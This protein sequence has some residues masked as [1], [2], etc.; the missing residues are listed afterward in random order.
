M[1]HQNSPEPAG[2]T[3]AGSG[4]SPITFTGLLDILGHNGFTAVCLKPVDGDFSATVTESADAANLAGVADA[5][6][7]FGVNPVTGPARGGRGSS[8]DV[9]ALSCL[10]VDFDVK[11]GACATLGDALTIVDDLSAILGTRPGVLIW[12]GHGVQ[13]LW[14]IEDDAAT[15]TSPK[16]RT[17]AVVLLKRWRRLVETVAGQRGAGVDAVFDLARILRIPG[18][19]NHKADPV[20]VVAT[21]DRGGPLTLDEIDDVLDEFGVPYPD[22]ESTNAAVD[23]DS[24]AWA[25][26]ACFYARRMIAGWATDSPIARHPWLVGQATRLAAARRHGCLTADE[27]QHGIDTLTTRMRELCTQ[28][29]ARA[30]PANEIRDAIAWGEHRVAQMSDERAAREL[31]GH[32][33]TD[34][35][36]EL[37]VV[38]FSPGGDD[39][40]TQPIAATTAPTLASYL[41]DGGSFIHDE[42]EG[43]TSLW[44][45]GDR[46][47]W[48]DGEALIICGPQGVGKTTLASNVLSALIADHPNDILGV[49]V[50]PVDRTLYLAMDRPRQASRA[51][52]RQLGH[53]SRDHLDKR[54]TF[55]KGPPP[56]DLAKNTRMLTELAEAAEADVVIV[57][58]LKDAAIGL[59]DDEVGAG[60]NRAR[61]ALLASGRNILELHHIKKISGDKKPDIADVYGSTWI[62]S[63]AGSVILLNGNPGDA[64]VRFHHVKQPIEE[65][66]PWMLLHEQQTGT[67]TV[68][69]QVDIVAS[70]A[71]SEGLTVKDAARLVFE[72]DTPDRNQIEKTRRRLNALVRDG[73]LMATEPG[74]PSPT[75]YVA[76]ARQEVA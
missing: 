68:H 14:L 42:P 64:V 1:A 34:N 56:H 24:F 53:Y 31:G 38:D 59:S 16:D 60:W 2:T 63:G 23:P 22:D 4:S 55:W 8:D 69:G 28:G 25:G 39:A 5:D 49:T 70:A 37:S 62:T 46:S 58:S 52:R 65:L 61:Q 41:I 75:T 15:F 51:L 71:R 30:L 44:G 3:S 18:T 72:T 48:A 33:H 13:P 20:P 32:T 54:M 21:H 67:M 50:K 73:R 40:G 29:E 35:V 7:W 74:K 43:I 47:L 57:D 11:D 10:W 36:Q 17:R 45:T 12:S 66:G 6:L 19:T 9:T 27:H 76:V 26:E